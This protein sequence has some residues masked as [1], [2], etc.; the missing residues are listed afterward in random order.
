MPTTQSFLATKTADRIDS[1]PRAS[2]EV[3]RRRGRVVEPDV[4]GEEMGLPPAY[5]LLRLLPLSTTTF[6][7]QP[8]ATPTKLKARKRELMD[9]PS[10]APTLSLSRRA[11]GRISVSARALP[12][13]A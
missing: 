12:F 7:P 10:A 8:N 5:P 4:E 13:A 6:A 2:A 3:V 9:L 11:G 1:D